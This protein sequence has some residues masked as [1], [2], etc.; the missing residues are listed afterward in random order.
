MIRNVVLVKLKAGSDA[1]EVAEIQKGFLNLGCPGTLSYTIGDDLGLREG[2]WSFAIVADFRDTDSY[3][4]YDQDAEHNRLRA[5]LGPMAEQIARAQF[6]LSLL[7]RR[8]IGRSAAPA[9]PVPASPAATSW[10][11]R[12]ARPGR[13][14]AGTAPP[15]R[16]P[17]FRHRARWRGS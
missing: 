14:A 11:T 3:R 6:E 17:E 12:T 9:G 10:P 5:R 15:R 1:A 4:A 13:A 8:V 2:T 7:I 16:R